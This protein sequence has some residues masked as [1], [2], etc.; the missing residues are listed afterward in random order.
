[1]LDCFLNYT[2][3]A[4][5]IGQVV[6]RV[7]VIRPELDSFAVLGDCLVDLPFL[8]KS[9]TNVVMGLRMIELQF[10]CFFIFAD[11]AIQISFSHKCVAEIIVRRGM[12]WS[13]SSRLVKIFYF[14]I[15]PPLM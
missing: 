11:C 8:P 7:G 10:Q 12:R 6:V 3:L 2:F 1:M 5:G 14:L 9:L 4:K 13:L 15:D